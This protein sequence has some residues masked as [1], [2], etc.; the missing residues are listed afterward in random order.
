MAKE[1]TTNVDTNA[2][3]TL[4]VADLLTVI[5]KI[6]AD[7]AEALAKSGE[8]NAEVLS[9][10]LEKLSPSY[11]TP[12]QKQNEQQLKQASRE[13]ELNKIRMKKRQQHFCDHEIGQ[14]GRKRLG[15]GA[16]FPMKM[17]TGEVIAVCCYCQKVISSINPK[18]EKFW[19]KVGGTMGEA[20]QISGLNDPIE[21]AL[22]RLTGDEQDAVRKSRL[23]YRKIV[24]TEIDNY[25]D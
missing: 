18:H 1:T 4:S 7:N 15:E 22:Q 19:K 23:E 8:R 24:P 12:G 11:K 5:A 6:Q 25:D 3:V 16:F 21:A 10:S 2:P 14:T 17:A 9:S 20:G 13:G